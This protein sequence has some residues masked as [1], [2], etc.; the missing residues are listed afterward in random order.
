MIVIP[1]GSDDSGGVCDSDN[2]LCNS[3]SQVAHWMIVAIAKIH[4]EAFVQAAD[5][6][7]MPIN[8][9]KV[10]PDEFLAMLHEA[11]IGVWAQHIV[12]KYLLDKGLHMMPTD[13]AM[14]DLGK[15]HYYHAPRR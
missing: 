3:A 14:L 15:M 8:S 11:N 5:N 9:E 1:E 7:G 2:E 10:G 4:G 12:R 6:L 13:R